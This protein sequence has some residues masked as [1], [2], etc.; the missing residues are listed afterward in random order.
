MTLFSYP[1]RMSPVATTMVLLHKQG[2]NVLVYLGKR[3]DRPG[4]TYGGWWSLP[5]GYMEAEK[6]GSRQT[7]TREIKEE[8][9]ITVDEDAWLIVGSDDVPGGDPR[10][11]QVINICY[12]VWVDE[13]DYKS[14]T[15]DDDLSDGKWVT[16]EE[17]VKTNL[18]FRH[19]MNL[20]WA[21]EKNELFLLSE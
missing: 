20:E 2:D 10:Y 19:N 17:A 9:G 3:R 6:E 12:S 11:P 21:I 4:A 15:P 7:A 5:G 8:T 14:A 13:A 1:F 18:A 16:I